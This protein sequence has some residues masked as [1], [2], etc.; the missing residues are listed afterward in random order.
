MTIAY[1]ENLVSSNKKLSFMI[2]WCNNQKMY[3]NI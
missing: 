1:H 2:S 3:N